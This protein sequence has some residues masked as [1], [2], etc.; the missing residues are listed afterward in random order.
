ME[1]DNLYKAAKTF[2][3]FSIGVLIFSFSIKIWTGGGGCCKTSW[4]TKNYSYLKDGGNVDIEVFAF[5][6]DEFDMSNIDD[7][8]KDKDL[9]DDI[10][11]ILK[12]EL[13]HSHQFDKEFI[14]TLKD[15]SIK[16]MKFKT[17]IDDGK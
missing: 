16:I 10:K 5:G 11:A 9:P 3:V 13:S 15:G 7:L 8:L 4:K 1:F 17:I 6:G 12:N 14:D 2:L